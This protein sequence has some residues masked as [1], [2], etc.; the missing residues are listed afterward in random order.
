MQNSHHYYKWEMLA[1]LF[2]AY[3][4]HQA[5]RAIFGVV[6]PLIRDDLHLTETQIGLTASVL[7]AVM[8]VMVPIAGFVGDRYSRKR[9]ITVSILF[10]SLTTMLTGICRTLGSLV[11]FRSIATGGSESFYGPASTAMIASYHKSTRALALSIHQASLYIGVMTSGFIAGGLAESFGW[12]STFYLF[13]GCGILIGLVLAFRLRDPEPQ[14]MDDRMDPGDN[15]RSLW[16]V[17][18]ILLK[19]PSV[20][21][22]TCGFIAIVFV[23]NAYLVWAPG[24]LEEKFQLSLTAAGG[25]AMFYHHL[26]ALLFILFGGWLSDRLAQRNLSYRVYMQAAAMLLGVPLIW[27]L[28]A[29]SSL[30]FVLTI[31]FL[32]GAV[33]GLYESSTHAAIFETVPEQYRASLCGLMI[34][35]A[36]LLGSTSPLLLGGLCDVY[37]KADGLSLGFKYLALAWLLGGLSVLAAALLTYPRDQK[38]VHQTFT[39]RRSPGENENE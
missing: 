11:F 16:S 25:Y 24:L 17:T 8:A 30:V 14:E 9:I 6:A 33:R 7:F 22:L 19:I 2:F 26:A 36:F 3:F 28:G 34:M 29:G 13:G 1:L 35:V 5:D 32:L 18:L 12:R 10:W 27:L 37:G 4:F 39:V 21:L 20:W 31:T 23:N 15:R 38:K